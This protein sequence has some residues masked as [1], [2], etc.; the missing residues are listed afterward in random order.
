MLHADGDSLQQLMFQLAME[1]EH[2]GILEAP[3]PLLSQQVGVEIYV[4]NLYD[5]YHFS[6]ISIDVNYFLYNIQMNQ[7]DQL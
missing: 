4:D 6:I 5:Q 1:Q 3:H 7:M 2:G